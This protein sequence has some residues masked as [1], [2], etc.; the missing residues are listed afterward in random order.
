M[1]LRNGKFSGKILRK[2]FRTGKFSMEN[3]PPHITTDRSKFDPRQ[4][5]KGFSSN[6]CVQTGSGA[7]PASCAMGTGGP[8]PGGKARPRRDVISY[9]LMILR[10]IGSVHMTL[11]PNTLRN[12]GVYLRIYTASQ[13]SRTFS[14]PPPWEPQ[15]SLWV[16]VLTLMRETK[17]H[18]HSKQQVEL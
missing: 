3:F 6:L 9:I 8:F 18:T 17:F 4:W 12:V 14:S 7:H 10:D 1:I 5:R 15:A 13:L 16:R 11:F 2:I